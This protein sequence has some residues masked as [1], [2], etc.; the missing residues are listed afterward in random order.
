MN[1]LILVIQTL[2][3]LY[4]L[5]GSF[6][7]ISNYVALANTWAYNTLPQAFWI[8]LGITQ[9]VL[10]IILLISGY[11]KKHRIGAYSSV[12]LAVITFSGI[13]LYSS[14]AGFPGMVWGILPA[15]VYAF[16]AYKRW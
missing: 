1:I 11:I 12:L 5:T 3:A 8:V 4:T 10:A 14:Y 15:L 2:L 9:I 16:I 13:F 7:M 6:Y